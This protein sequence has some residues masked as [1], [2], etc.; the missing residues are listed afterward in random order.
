MYDVIDNFGLCREIVYV[1]ISYLD[2]FLCSLLKSEEYRESPKR[3]IGVELFQ[4]ASL[5]SLYLSIKIHNPQKMNVKNMAQLSR[6]HASQICWMERHMLSVL[7]WNVHPPTT[8]EFS[9]KF[10]S[11]LSNVS[12]VQERFI[13]CHYI[14]KVFELSEFLLE[15]SVWDPYFICLQPST[16]AIAAV[17]NAMEIVHYDLSQK[18]QP[19]FMEILRCTGMQ[20]KL[21]NLA[22]YRNRLHE[23]YLC[24][25][26][27]FRQ[28]NLD[29]DE[30]DND[31]PD[32][33]ELDEEHRV[34]SP[35]GVIIYSFDANKR[36]TANV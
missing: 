33:F 1:A 21:S 5:T 15:L 16:T 10:M 27:C 29:N 12:H 24:S 36:G 18:F 28:Q 7:S 17:L 31:E 14:Q 3:A 34:Q 13:V 26:E 23:D 32:K 20:P 11:L 9:R 22:D 30:D 6:F 2:R 19:I 35:T 25:E 4:L 8:M